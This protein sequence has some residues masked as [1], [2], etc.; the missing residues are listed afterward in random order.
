MRSSGRLPPFRTAPV[1]FALLAFEPVPL[2]D[3]AGLHVPGAL[4]G[5]F[6]LPGSGERSGKR[7]VQLTAP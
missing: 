4:A 7:T 1:S 6:W 5:I 2:G 3:R